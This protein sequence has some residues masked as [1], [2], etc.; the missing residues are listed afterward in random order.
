MNDVFAKVHNYWI[1][2]DGKLVIITVDDNFPPNSKSMIAI[3]T[4]PEHG[5]QIWDGARWNDPPGYS[6]PFNISF[7]QLIDLLI[8]KGVLTRAELVLLSSPP[9]DNPADDKGNAP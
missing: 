7:D 3:H 5:K 6:P 9:P 2:K 1:D 4:A 8:S